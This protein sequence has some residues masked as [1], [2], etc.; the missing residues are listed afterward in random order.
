MR[1]ELG[2]A[3]QPTQREK[4]RNEKKTHLNRELRE[5]PLVRLAMRKHIIAIVT[6]I[7]TITENIPRIAQVVF[8]LVVCT[9]GGVPVP[10][11]VRRE[12]GGLVPGVADHHDFVGHGFVHGVA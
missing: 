3:P 4:E 9:G 2:P 8:N 7:V 11:V 10:L 12:H 1:W 5:P 6:V